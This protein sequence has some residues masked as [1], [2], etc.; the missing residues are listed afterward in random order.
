MKASGSGLRAR[1]SFLCRRAQVRSRVSS[2]NMVPGTQRQV[3]QLRMAYGTADGS[4]I[5]KML[6]KDVGVHGGFLMYCR[7]LS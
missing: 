6:G 4:P 5:H 7:A 1:C 2:A 3:D